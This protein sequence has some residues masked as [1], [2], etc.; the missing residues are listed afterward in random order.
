[1]DSY[2]GTFILDLGVNLDFY[3]VLSP[4]LGFTIDNFSAISS[5]QWSFDYS[6]TTSDIDFS[7][8]T[9][10]FVFKRQGQPIYFCYKIKFDIDLPCPNIPTEC[11]S[12]WTKSVMCSHLDDEGL[13]MFPTGLMSIPIPEGYALCD[14]KEWKLL[15]ICFGLT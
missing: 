11:K 10:L 8:T 2:D 3:E 7:G 14:N 9:A 12:N 15:M 1:L 5:T 4:E 13:V 6:I